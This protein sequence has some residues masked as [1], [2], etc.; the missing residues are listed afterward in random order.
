MF[1]HNTRSYRQSLGGIFIPGTNG[2]GGEREKQQAITDTGQVC[3]GR[4]GALCFQNKVNDDAVDTGAPDAGG[5]G[6]DG[7]GVQPHQVLPVQFD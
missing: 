1:E 3:V 2:Y 6:A 4:R 5:L 7:Q